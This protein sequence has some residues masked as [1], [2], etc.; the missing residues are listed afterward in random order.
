LASLHNRIADI[1]S[2]EL[3]LD[4]ATRDYISANLGFR[5]IAMPDEIAGSDQDGMMKRI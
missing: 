3:S 4:A 1:T 5:W 2:G